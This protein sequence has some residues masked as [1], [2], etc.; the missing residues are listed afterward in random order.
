MI[1]NV[2]GIVVGDHNDMREAADLQERM[3]MM[4]AQLYCKKTKKSENEIK[5]MMDNDTYLF[6]TEIKDMGFADNII[7]TEKSKDK[8]NAIDTAHTMYK[9]VQKAMKEEKLSVS[10]LK[11]QF[12]LCV[13]NCSLATMPSD[14]EKIANSNLGASMEFNIENFNLLVEQT[15]VLKANKETMSAR[16]ETLTMQLEEATT[17]LDTTKAELS[18]KTEKLNGMEA[19]LS[20]AIAK[21]ADAETRV[22]EAITLKV[23]AD[24]AVKMLVADTAESASALAN[25]F[26]GSNGASGKA[27]GNVTSQEDPWANMNFK[28]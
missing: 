21:T 5:T 4:L 3:S 9:K 27:D 18:Q 25:A 23:D 20:E 7:D 6:G 2:Q 13:G 19:Q 15:K 10:A 1:H 26:R 11:E 14:N 16:N 12:K 22:R 17:A 28:R 24:T 8:T